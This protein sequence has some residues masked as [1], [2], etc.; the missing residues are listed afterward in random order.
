MPDLGQAPRAEEAL[1]TEPKRHAAVC[2]KLVLDCSTRP[3]RHYPGFENKA[4]TPD[5]RSV[6]ETRCSRRDK[7]FILRAGWRL[8]LQHPAMCEI[9]EFR[10]DHRPIL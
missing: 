1:A 3:S 4:L 8:T 2:R 5:V 10:R 9:L 7:P 6:C